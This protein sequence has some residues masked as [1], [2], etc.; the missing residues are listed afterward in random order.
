MKKFTILA[1]SALFFGCNTSVKID[2]KPDDD[3]YK[4][5]EYVK[6]KHPDWSKNA[7]IYEANIRQFTP[8][9]TFKAFETHLP[10]L[11]EMGVD[12]VWLM[13]IHP[14][15]NEKRKGTLG[16]E[17]SVK[18]YF[19]VNPE[20]GTKQDFK[21][22]VDKVH[23]M[24]MH[25]IIDWVANHSAW[26]NPLAKQH[27]DW[28][29]KT[30]EGHF[31]PTPWYD[32]DDV[33]D[34]D[35][36]K[37]ELRKYMTSALVYWVKDFNIDGYR[38]DTAGFIPTD[39]WNNARAEMD[40]VKPVFMLGEWE[41]RDLHE[42][43]FDA[44]YSWSFWN[45]MTAVTKDGK[46]IGQLVEY[47]AHDVS[48][49]PR[50]AYRMTFTDN[51][52]KNSWEGNMVSNFGDGLEASMVLCGTVNGM[53]L[54]YG[55]Q[56]AG[57]DKSLKFFDKDEI[58]WSNLN[59]APLYK[60]LFDLKHRNKALWNGRNGG[61]MIRIFNDKMNQVVSFSRTMDNDRV[62]TIVNYSKEPTKVKLDS[63]YQKGTYTELFSG[64][65]IVLNGDDT[66]EMKPWEYLVLVK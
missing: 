34:F 23:E 61:V 44:T 8:E 51:H 52:D 14:I 38:C 35:Y 29:S 17:Y 31:Q 11:K 47:M 13:P 12:I 37:P 62:V 56:E 59:Y 4:P 41:S 66:F 60:K 40:A 63:K 64:K 27:P 22:L 3:R 49:F 54:V 19:D 39:F 58:D 65:T 28:Y 24:G 32:W 33:I 6:V 25:I 10:R 45:A 30:P 57:L 48:T 42:Y 20:F 5:I 9:G 2:N 55:G 18:D 16:S 36:D 7:T 53:P 46:S 43:A 26:D 15:G 1:L 50:D 21:H